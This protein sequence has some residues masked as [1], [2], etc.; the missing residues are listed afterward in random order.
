MEPTEIDDRAAL[1]GAFAA[2]RFLLFKHSRICP[3]SDRAF[4]QYRAFLAEHPDT[5]TAWLDVIASRPLSQEV[6]ARTGVQHES[7][8]ALLLEHGAARWNA[9]HGAVT[10]DSLAEA[11]LQSGS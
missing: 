3:V 10:R 8:Q 11:V 5:P 1:E 9:S 7:P 6:A 4:A 2:E